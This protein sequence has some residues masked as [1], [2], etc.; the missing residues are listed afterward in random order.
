MV[1]F[2]SKLLY[3]RATQSIPAGVNSPVRSFINVGLTPFFIKRADGSKVYDVD[4]NEYID[5]VGSWGPMILG[6]NHPKVKK[7]VLQAVQ[8]G[9]SYGAPHQ[10]EIILAEKI[11][12]FFPSMD[13]LRM[14][15][16]GTE[17]A[18]SAIRVARGFTQ[19]EKIIKLIG[20]YHG[21]ADYLLA[22]AGSGAS[23]LNIPDSLGVPKSLLLDTLLADYN[24]IKSLEKLLELHSSNVAAIILEPIAG[25]MGFILPQNNF[26][27]NVRKLCDL[28]GV[29]LIFDEVMTGFRVAKGGAQELFSIVPDLTILGKIVGGGLP[30]GIYGGRKDIM[31]VVAPLGSVYQAGT[32]SGNPVATAAGIATLQELEKKGVYEEL[33]QK[34]NWLVQELQ[35]VFQ[36]HKLN[37]TIQA[38]GGMFGFFLLKKDAPTRINSYQDIDFIDKKLFSK[39]FKQL[40]IEKIAIAPSVFEAGFMSLAHTQQDLFYTVNAFDRA[41][42]K[43][44]SAK[45]PI[46]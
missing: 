41:L 1:N 11:K 8:N 36:K 3:Q 28:H 26:L 35:K 23:T 29:L 13:L 20:C 37:F 25:N 33:G 27:Q 12:Q 17:A 15:N 40:L 38:S 42:Q 32:L 18:M 30:I 4:N 2:Q 9:L 19:K 43:T 7:A 10:A 6:H 14:V 39:L 22:K 5:F 16:S 46:S 24:D 44:L 31:E 21:H 34:T 45:N